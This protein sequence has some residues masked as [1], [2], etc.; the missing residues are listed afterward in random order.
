MTETDKVMDTLLC[1]YFC[2]F[3]TVAVPELRENCDW[4]GQ[5]EYCRDYQAGKFKPSFPMPAIRYGTMLLNYKGEHRFVCVYA[6]Q[7][8]GY[9]TL[10]SDEYIKD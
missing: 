3:R 4:K 1:D 7:W 9:A 6:N 2:V 10:I 8:G 5:C